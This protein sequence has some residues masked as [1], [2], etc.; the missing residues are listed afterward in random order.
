MI[1]ITDPRG[2]GKTTLMLQHIKEE[3]Y[4]KTN[5]MK[6]DI[7]AGYMN[8]VSLWQLGAESRII[9]YKI[10]QKCEYFIPCLTYPPMS[11]LYILSDIFLTRL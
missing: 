4:R 1:G 10:R 3:L 8:V 11:S 7:E 9:K 5:V 6:D 2:V